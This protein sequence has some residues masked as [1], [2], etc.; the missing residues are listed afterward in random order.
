[1]SEV[2]TADKIGKQVDVRLGDV[3]ICADYSEILHNPSPRIFR[4]LKWRRHFLFHLPA[5]YSNYDIP[6]YNRYMSKVLPVL[7]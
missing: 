6:A 3:Y 5:F 4:P 2:R 1:M 7:L